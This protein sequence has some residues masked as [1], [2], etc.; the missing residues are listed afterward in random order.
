MLRHGDE[1]HGSQRCLLGEGTIDLNMD[2]SDNFFVSISRLNMDVSNTNTFLD[3]KTD[4]MDY[5]SNFHHW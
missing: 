4:D 1:S 2:V 3:V 5:S